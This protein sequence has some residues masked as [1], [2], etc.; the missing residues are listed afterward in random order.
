MTV[1]E[2]RLFADII[3]AASA[4]FEPAQS[5]L[6]LVNASKQTEVAMAVAIALQYQIKNGAA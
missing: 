6:A 4:E 5:N 2:S 3:N 1:N